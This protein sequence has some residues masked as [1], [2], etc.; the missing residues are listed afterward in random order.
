MRDSGVKNVIVGS[1]HDESYEQA[2]EDGFM[3]YPIEK[4]VKEADII[5][6]LFLLYAC[7]KIQVL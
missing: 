3:V 7:R 5:F 6:L 2:N 4:A 1:R